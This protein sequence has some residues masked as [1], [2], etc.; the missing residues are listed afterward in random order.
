MRTISAASAL[1]E[2]SRDAGLIKLTPRLA[3]VAEDESE[4]A[5]CL[6]EAAGGEL[7]ITPRGGGTSI[8]SQSVGSGAI[9]LQGGRALDVAPDGTVVCQPAVVKADLNSALGS[10]RWMPVDPSSYA[11]CTVGGMVS[12]NSSG[13]RTPKYGSTI[14]YV[15]RLR[16]VI[17]GEDASQV[18]PMPVEA[19]LSGP[20]RL[21]KAAS[22]VV[23]NQGDI[24]RDRPGVTKN[25]SG[26]RLERILHDGV[27]DLPKLFVGSE[28]TLGVL[29]EVEVKTRTR[30]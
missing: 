14:D 6:R 11:S 3:Y 13:A 25:S 7:S 9:L 28:G 5:Q 8:P 18:A 26:Y 21:R 19:A 27:F 15:D 10:Q 1:E 29:T 23:E 24:S 30:P 22:L 20:A 2:L 12:N 4:V 16:V 17:P